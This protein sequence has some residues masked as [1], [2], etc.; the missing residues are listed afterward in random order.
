MGWFRSTVKSGVAPEPMPTYLFSFDEAD[1]GAPV[2]PRNSNLTRFVGEP[3][4]TSYASS[5]TYNNFSRLSSG[6]SN[7]I[8]NV[9][10]KLP[11]MQ[12][13]FSGTDDSLKFIIKNIYVDSPMANGEATNL[14]KFAKI[15]GDV[16]VG[17][18]IANVYGMFYNVNFLP[19]T[20]LH[21]GNSINSAS[22]L[23]FKA[24]LRNIPDIYINGVTPNIDTM[25]ER[26]SILD[27]NNQHGNINV[28]VKSTPQNT[29][30][31]LNGA[32]FS[33]V[34]IYAPDVTK[35]RTRSIVNTT[36]S[37]SYDAANDCYYNTARNIYL[38]NN[39][40]F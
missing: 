16:I 38:Y 14:F 15:S 10:L 36:L 22:H 5:L 6:V 3:D 39:Y 33:R 4:A 7:N 17:D 11:S 20:N 1:G 9:K 23:F 28:Y 21:L 19:N 26:T 2:S 27:S 35:F 29:V 40:I 8:S 12:G 24:R 30:N 25:M 31:M 13:V 18:N 37:W 34:N 32:S